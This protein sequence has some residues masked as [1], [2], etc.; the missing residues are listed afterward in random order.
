MI[1]F[2]I[3]ADCTVMP[4]FYEKEHQNLN[5]R[6]AKM[7]FALLVANASKQ[8]FRRSTF[9]KMILQTVKVAV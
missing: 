9:R 4:S 5:E 8:V 7:L 3:P 6:L 1:V 2:L